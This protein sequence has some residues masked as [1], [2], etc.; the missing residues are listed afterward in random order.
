MEELITE[1]EGERELLHHLPH[2]VQEQ[3]E[4]RGAVSLRGRCHMAVTKTERIASIQPLSLNQTCK[5]VSQVIAK[6]GSI[7]DGN[8]TWHYG[9][10]FENQSFTFSMCP[11]IYKLAK[12]TYN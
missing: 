7:R 5:P 1:L 3:Q 4:D 8:G 11:E 2:T 12:C 6:Y 9:I 10:H